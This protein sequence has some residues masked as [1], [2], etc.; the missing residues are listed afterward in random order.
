MVRNDICY[1]N[2]PV[3]I[4]GM[5]AGTIYSTLGGTHLT[6]EDISIARS[7]PNMNIIAPCDPS[8]L[9][10][11]INFCC[12]KS[13]SP[14]YLRI[15][16]AG[17]KD[18]TKNLKDKWK[19]GK[20]RKIFPGNDLCFLT[21]GPIVTKAFDLKN[22]LSKKNISSEIYS[23]HTLKP[24]DYSGLR[25]IFKKFKL[26]VI[27]EDHSKIGGLNNI[28]K[29]FAYETRY[30]GSIISYSLKDEFIHCYGSQDDLLNK[31]GISTNKILN[32]IINS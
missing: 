23:C 22:S 11:A 12:T 18:F 27:I 4:V 19:F 25:K 13:K 31:H 1:Q 15:G 32:K 3:T 6:Q 10:H 5:G 9:K 24:F 26:I 14:V 7:I 16:K 20:I 28:V 29:T 21:F 30:T 2:L 8:E 17:E